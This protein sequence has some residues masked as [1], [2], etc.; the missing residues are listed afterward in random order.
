MKKLINILAI[1][2][3]AYWQIST[4]V[5]AQEAFIDIPTAFS[6]DGDGINDKLK[7]LANNIDEIE[8][9]IYNRWGNLVF[10]TDDINKGWAGDFNGNGTIQEMDVYMV[11]IEAEFTNG[12]PP[13]KERRRVTLLK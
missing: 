2:S 11:Y 9:R 3:L 10:E 13:V 8:F 4:L 12:D 7:I 6:P 5:F 1:S